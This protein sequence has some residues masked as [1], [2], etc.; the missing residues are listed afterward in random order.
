MRRTGVILATGFPAVTGISAA[1]RKNGN[2]AET[3]VNVTVPW[4]A[5]PTDVC[6]TFG[7]PC[8]F[9]DAIFSRTTA[10]ASPR[11]SDLKVPLDRARRV[12]EN[13]GE[14]DERH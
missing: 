10:A 3:S 2:L 11:A 1:V 4:S 13:T 9:T 5:C 14:R 7:A 12:M 8:L 6:E